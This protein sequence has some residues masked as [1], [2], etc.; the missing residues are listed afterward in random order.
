MILTKL[1]YAKYIEK[2][3]NNFFPDG[4]DICDNHLQK[5][6]DIALQRLEY[7][8][9]RIKLNSFDKFNYLH[10]DQYAMFLYIVSNELF[11]NFENIELAVKVMYLNK[12]LHSVNCMY[13]NELPPVFVFIHITG[14]VI[15]KAQFGNYLTLYQNVTIGSNKEV[16]PSFGDFVT[17]CAGSSVIGGA[18]IGSNVTIGAG[19]RI[20]NTNIENNHNAILNSNNLLEVREAKSAYADLIFKKGT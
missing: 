4:K 14:T 13:D 1:N 18:Q 19:A 5:A 12:I 3:I 17:L 7:C 20:F 2:Q 11:K 16:Y 6:V 10:T 15:G 9:D 8:F